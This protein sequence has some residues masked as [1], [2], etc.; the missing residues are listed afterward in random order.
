MS[1][2]GIAFSAFHRKATFLLSQRKLHFHN[3]LTV[4]AF[5][6]VIGHN[7]KEACNRLLSN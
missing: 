1:I 5:V 7:R 3:A 4:I 6:I 2:H